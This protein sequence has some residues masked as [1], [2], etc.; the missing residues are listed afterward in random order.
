M[1]RLI[2]PVAFFAFVACSQA[3]KKK[4]VDAGADP[5]SDQ[6]ADRSGSDGRATDASADMIAPGDGGGTP[7]AASGL[8][9]SVE[10][11]TDL[12]VDTGTPGVLPVE[13]L[14]KDCPAYM[15]DVAQCGYAAL[16]LDYSGASGGEL[17]VFF[18]RVEGQA[19]KSDKK[20]QIWFLQ[21]GPGGSGVDFV[22][23]FEAWA[24]KHPEWDFYSLDH[25]GV[26]N[27]ARLG[28]MQE[29][30][31]ATMDFEGIEKCL[32]Y[33]NSQWGEGVLKHFTTSNAARD[34]AHV[35]EAN[36]EPGV[37]AYVYGVSYGTYW[38]HRYMQL[39]P[40]QADAIVL[41]SLALPGLLYIDNFDYWF[42]ENGR[43]IFERCGEDETCSSTMAFVADTP[44]EAVGHV[45]EQVDSGQLC[46][47]FAD[48]ISRP[49]LRNILGFM[50][51]DWFT[52]ILMPAA[53]FR[54]QRCAPEDIQALGN[55]Y[56]YLQNMESQVPEEIAK[57]Y[58][59]VLGE[60]I[61]QA[62]LLEGKSPEEVL[63]IIQEAFVSSDTAY[64]PALISEWGKWPVY[65]D[66]GTF[67][68]LSD[69]TV[70]LLMLNG[71]LDPQTPIDT[72]LPA[73]DHFNGQ[74]QHFVEMPWAPHGVVFVSYTKE[75]LETQEG[76]KCGEQIMF[77]FLSDPAATPDTSCLADLAPLEF[78]AD[79]EVNKATS[80]ELFGTPD[81]WNGTP[82]RRDPNVNLT[83]YGRMIRTSVKTT[84]RSLKQRL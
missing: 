34:L 38:A 61:L 77:D 56:S 25:R 5:L 63:A 29:M 23:L 60:H 14:W 52:R 46:A 26:G 12:S 42:N 55:F 57:L 1:A 16:P 41:D 50:S 13:L 11:D 67:G 7:D 28:C 81:M 4:P 53:V 2:L 71:N 39:F 59:I 9:S 31:F 49:M 37:P 58:S 62:E 80:L 10:V 54:V 51:A 22:F 32:N 44:W 75:N 21:G 73:A 78:S 70:P 17:S 79:S 36:R 35:V 47:E 83:P 40:E 19:E 82:V 8:D 48:V 24:Q 72:A 64:G 74:N 20:G 45:F 69:A 84:L 15:P 66:D 30:A 6:V 68:K 3:G 33:L 65:E 18:Y 27:T 76:L 43:R